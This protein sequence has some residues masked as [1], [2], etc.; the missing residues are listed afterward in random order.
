M[1]TASN[2]MSTDHLKDAD[3]GDVDVD[4]LDAGDDDEDMDDDLKN[5]LQKVND[6][7][8]SSK[9]LT[10]SSPEKLLSMQQGM[11]YLAAYLAFK[12]KDKTL[13]TVSAKTPSSSMNN[14]MWLWSMS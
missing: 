11:S 2:E 5:L 10:F 9:T 3:A 4:G 12:C 14:T 1:S 13:G 8:H 6:V 7:T